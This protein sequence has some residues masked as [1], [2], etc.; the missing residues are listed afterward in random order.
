MTY[1][2]KLDAILDRLGSIESVLLTVPPDV[3]KPDDLG[4]V[5]PAVRDVSP[6]LDKRMTSPDPVEAKARA[7]H[8]VSWAGTVLSD[9]RYDKAWEEVSY[10]LAAQPFDPRCAPYLGTNPEVALYGLLSG[11][12]ALPDETNFFGEYGG[13]RDPQ[14]LRDV[15]SIADYL[16]GLPAFSHGGGPSGR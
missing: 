10:L 11:M 1:D 14:R 5:K 3:A 9:E 15:A 13:S 2:E 4:F 6:W 8:G 16:A 7:L 12:V